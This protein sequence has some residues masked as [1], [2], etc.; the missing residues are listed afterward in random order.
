M[1][2]AALNDGRLQAFTEVSLLGNLTILDYFG[3]LKCLS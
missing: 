1:H 2:D 3:L